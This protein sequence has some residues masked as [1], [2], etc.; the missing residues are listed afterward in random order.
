[1]RLSA[2]RALPPPLRLRR[3]PA[4]ACPTWL[5]SELAVRT[6]S[7]FL[8]ESLIL[9]FDG[10]EDASIST[11]QALAGND[12]VAQGRLVGSVGPVILDHSG[13]FVGRIQ[14]IDLPDEIERCVDRQRYAAACD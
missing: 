1:M 10:R 7:K 6:C 3:R 13:H 4:R 2:S 14:P 9:A 5:E 8:I 12:E 11:D